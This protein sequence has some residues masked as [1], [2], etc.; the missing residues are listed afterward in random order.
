MIDNNQRR[1]KIW[2]RIASVI[3]SILLWF[4]VVNQGNVATGGNLM[5]VELKYYNVPTDLNV[6]GPDKV[7]VKLWGSFHGS[8]NIIAYVD[9]NGL[10]KGTYQIPVKLETVQG[11]MFT[12]VQ[13]NKVEVKL[14]ALSERVIQVKH[15]VK[16]NPQTGY[17]VS[18]VV[19]SPDRCMIKGDVDAV[20]KVAVVVAPISLG[21]VKDIASVKSKLQA[22]DAKGKVITEGIQ[23]LPAAIDVYVVV[24][25]KQITKKVNINSQFT[26]QLPEGYSMGELKS[27][28]AQVTILGEQTRL[29]SLSE[30]LTKP[31]DI[32]GKKEDF[33]QIVELVQPEGVTALP[34]KITLQVKIIKA[35]ANEVQR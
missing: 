18:E 11:A 27:D 24:E 35:D 17:Q 28:P 8:A 14:E 31:I 12:S 9:L 23:I 3:M 33:V 13:P 19:L 5:E 34:S 2:L 32:T 15:E 1:K 6:T 4:Y 21:T 7:S 29:E 10:G 22:R 20:G 30:I 16:Q 25:K 26:G